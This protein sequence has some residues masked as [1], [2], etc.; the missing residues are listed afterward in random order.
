V[1]LA[2]RYSDDEPGSPWDHVLYVDDRGTGEQR[3]A[4]TEVFTGR[5]GG[6]ALDHFPWAWKPSRLLAVRPARVELDH[7]SERSWL[8]VESRVR[9]RISHRFEGQPAVTCGIPGHHQRGDELV[10]E[11]LVV[12]E[13][14]FAFELEANCAYRSVFDYSG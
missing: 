1:A 10:A 5:L 4:L 7:V 11:E 14:A 6:S 8:R 2:L 13:D 3:N 9:L 12:S